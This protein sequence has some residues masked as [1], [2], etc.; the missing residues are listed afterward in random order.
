MDH[1]LTSGLR[2]VIA[3]GFKITVFYLS[4]TLPALR[5]FEH[6][7][8]Y[9]IYHPRLR[10]NI[11]VGVLIDHM[12]TTCTYICFRYGGTSIYVKFLGM[13]PLAKFS[14]FRVA[15]AKQNLL[16]QNLSCN[17]LYNTKYCW[18]HITELK[19]SIVAVMQHVCQ[20]T[21]STSLHT[22]QPF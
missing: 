10:R 5:Q 15:R 2:E 13:F 4:Y 12:L 6:T 16:T 17:M 8:C 9:M 7:K 18:R 1:I 21:L 14:C 19:P 22:H 11:Q 3:A 20:V